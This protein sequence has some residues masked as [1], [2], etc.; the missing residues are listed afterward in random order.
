MLCTVV[1]EN[2]AEV[3]SK[4]SL[5]RWLQYSLLV[6]RRRLGLHS[7]AH[8]SSTLDMP[9]PFIRTRLLETLGSITF[10]SFIDDDLI[11]EGYS[12]AEELFLLKNADIKEGPTASSLVESNKGIVLDLHANSTA[13]GSRFESPTWWK[14]LLSLKPI[15]LNALLTYAPSPLNPSITS[16]YLSSRFKSS[17]RR[18]PATVVHHQGRNKSRSKV[19]VSRME[20][21]LVS[22]VRR[23]IPFESLRELSEEIGF[24]SDDV[25]GFTRMLEVNLLVPRLNDR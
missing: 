21:L 7:T 17:V 9:I 13:S 6:L 4:L 15:G 20:S 2:A 1:E 14:H 3:S 22:H 24:C 19:P 10:V 12:I 16:R 11:C 23:P 18:R 5:T 25:V 8:S